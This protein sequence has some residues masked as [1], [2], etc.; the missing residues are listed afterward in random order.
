M[1]NDHSTINSCFVSLYIDNSHLNM[2]IRMPLLEPYIIVF[3]SNILVLSVFVV[4]TSFLVGSL[5]DFEKS[6]K[7]WGKSE[8]LFL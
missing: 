5:P 7:I 6:E 8:K 2:F 1:F 3:T 4:V